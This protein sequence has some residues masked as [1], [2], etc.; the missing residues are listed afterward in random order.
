MKN[1]AIRQRIKNIDPGVEQNSSFLAVVV[2][3]DFL[4]NIK[5]FG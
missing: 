3:I 1:A 2:L 4:K 5:R